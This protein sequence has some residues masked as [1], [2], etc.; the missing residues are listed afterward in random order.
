MGGK[1]GGS[2]KCKFSGKEQENKER[3]VMGILMSTGTT[4]FDTSAWSRGM[5]LP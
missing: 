4:F 5:I 1:F 2:G 3:F